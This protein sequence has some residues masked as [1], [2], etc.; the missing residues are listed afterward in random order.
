M[1]SA[2]WKD[3]TPE[4]KTVLITL[5]MMAPFKGNKWIFKGE[6]IQTSAGEFVTSIKSIVANCGRGIS[7]QNVRTALSKLEKFEFLTSQSTNKSRKVSIVNWDTYQGDDRSLNKQ[8]NKQLTSNQ[9]ATNKQL[10]TIEE[11]KKEKKVKKKE[12][13]Y[14][15]VQHLSLS[16]INFEKLVKEGYRQCDIDD[17]LDGME[18][19]SKLKSYKSAILTARRWLKKQ[20]GA[21]VN[22][23][24]SGTMPTTTEQITPEI[25]QFMEEVNGSNVKF[26]KRWGKTQSDIAFDIQKMLDEISQ[27]VLYKRIG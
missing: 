2:L 13:I 23:L 26:A 3:C 1:E 20:H 16:R 6:E 22:G 18:N 19:Y 21:P 24:Q 11:G 8:S 27:E 17:V 25:R 9:Q 15:K 7:T 10:T 4:Q 12:E 14:R 5:L